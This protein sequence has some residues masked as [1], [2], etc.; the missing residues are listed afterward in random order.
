MELQAGFHGNVTGPA[1]NPPRPLP[2]PCI[3][4]DVMS[5]LNRPRPMVEP[6]IEM[7]LAVLAAAIV[8]CG[9]MGLEALPLLPL[10]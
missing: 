10:S 8:L 5:S 9:A 6:V 4:E 3:K 2:G 7:L 1:E